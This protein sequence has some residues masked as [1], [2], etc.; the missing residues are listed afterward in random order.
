MDLRWKKIKEKD[1]PFLFLLRW[2]NYWCM[3]KYSRII[4]RDRY[5]SVD[6]VVDISPDDKLV[7]TSSDSNVLGESKTSQVWLLKL[8]LDYPLWWVQKSPLWLVVGV[9]HYNKK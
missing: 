2:Y 4:M 1:K 8:P 5:Y 6:R 7:Q 3:Y 9:L